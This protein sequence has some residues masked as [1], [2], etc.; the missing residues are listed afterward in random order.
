[1]GRTENPTDRLEASRGHR[2][3]AKEIGPNQ[4][5]FR[6]DD[7]VRPKNNLT[8]PALLEMSGNA[9]YQALNSVDPGDIIRPV[10]KLKH[11]AQWFAISGS[12]GVAV[13]IILYLYGAVPFT[14][15]LVVRASSVLC[16]EMSLGLAEPSSP[17]AIALLLAW[18][19]LT[20]FVLYGI[21]GTALRAV[22]SLLR[23]A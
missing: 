14:R 4:P 10:T 3:W 15:R 8:E 18:V 13:A 19:F 2:H 6:V 20:N 12:A 17:S 23:P 11:L 16:P 1:M 21:V 9:T 5:L 22:W 7:G